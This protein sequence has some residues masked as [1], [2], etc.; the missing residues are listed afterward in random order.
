MLTAAFTRG[1]L[2]VLSMRSLPSAAPLTNRPSMHARKLSCNLRM[3]VFK[4]ACYVVRWTGRHWARAR[5]G[6]VRSGGKIRWRS[7][8]QAAE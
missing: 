7:T 8:T 1:V 2:A 4:L 5:C 3:H 6:A